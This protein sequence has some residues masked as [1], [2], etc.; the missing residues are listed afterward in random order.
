MNGNANAESGLPDPNMPIAVIG[1]STRFPGGADSPE[2]LWKMIS[3]GKSA[4]SKIP[5]DRFAPG[6]F[7]HPDSDRNG[8]VRTM[9]V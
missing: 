4:W 6:S 5:E 9:C 1:I 3:K 8:T 2:G 7:Y